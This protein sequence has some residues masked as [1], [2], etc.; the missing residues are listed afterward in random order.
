MEESPHRQLDEVN[1]FWWIW[2]AKVAGFRH[3]DFSPSW[4]IYA[5][6]WTAQTWRYAISIA[7]LLG[8]KFSAIFSTVDVRAAGV[9]RHGG[10][11]QVV[12]ASSRSM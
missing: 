2:S 3:P 1:S 7:T 6:D 8:G 12:L 4:Q 11:L 9:S 10:N 5:A